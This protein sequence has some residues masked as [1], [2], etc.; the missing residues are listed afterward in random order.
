MDSVL[1]LA[2]DGIGPEIMEQAKKI[3]SLFKDIVHYD[4]ALIGGA[5]IETLGNPYPTVTSEKAKNASAILLGAVGGPQWDSLSIE[6]RPEKGLLAIRKDLNL[7]ANLRPLIIW[8]SLVDFSPVKQELLTNVSFLIVRELTSDVYFG[9]PRGI[10]ATK[11]WNTMSYTVD[12]IR[13]IAHKA[14]QLAQSRTKKLC[15]IDKAN[16]LESMVLWRSVVNEIHHDYPD[17][18]LS[19][20]YVDN[21]AMQIIRRPSEFDVIL[22]PNMFGDIL[23]DESAVLSGSL[24]LLPS[25][26]LGNQYGLYEPIHGSAPDI[27]GQGIANPI[28]LI[29]SLAMLFEHTCQKPQIAQKIEYAVASILEQGYRTQDIY[30]PGTKLVSTDKMGDLIAE[31]CRTHL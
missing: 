21:A 1:L 3:L 25:A 23:S 8:P 15:S 4:E 12:E 6:N 13:K 31:S 14:F 19:H 10:T 27:A 5:A 29:L 24:G 18:I 28:G 11:A 2:G 30:S 16:V 17:V 26:S 22:T 7:Y 9:E 20:M